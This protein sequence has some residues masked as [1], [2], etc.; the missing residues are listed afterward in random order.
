MTIE[1]TVK[2]YLEFLNKGDDDK[3]ELFQE[4]KKGSVQFSLNKIPNLVNDKRIL[5]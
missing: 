1:E 2:Q 4:A 5:W 3:K